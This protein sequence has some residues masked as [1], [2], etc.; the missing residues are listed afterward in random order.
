MDATSVSGMGLQC[1]VNLVPFDCPPGPSLSR[2][3]APLCLPHA[4]RRRTASHPEQA[5]NETDLCSALRMRLDYVACIWPDTFDDKQSG[6]RSSTSSPL[7]KMFPSNDPLIRE[8][9]HTEFQQEIHLSHTSVSHLNRNGEGAFTW[10]G[11]LQ[12]TLT[13]CSV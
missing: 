3:L 1:R 6:I 13:S 7:L 8:S 2:P 9:R 11:E 5:L 12:C 4:E 10:A